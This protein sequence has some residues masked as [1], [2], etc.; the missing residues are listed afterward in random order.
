MGNKR[1][2]AEV[3]KG[4]DFHYGIYHYGAQCFSYQPAGEKPILWLSEFA[5]YQEG[6]PIRGGIPIILPWFSKGIHGDSS[7]SHG[8]ARISK[9]KLLEKTESRKNRTLTATF[10]LDSKAAGD[11]ARN[12]LATYEIYCSSE[13]LEAQLSITNT[14]TELFRMENALHTY[15]AVGDI[16]AVTIEGLDQSVYFDKTSTA[17]QKNRL[18]E[19]PVNIIGE[20]DRVYLS[21]GKIVV[22]DPTWKRQ[23]LIQK[24]GSANTVIWNPGAELASQMQDFGNDEW[25]QMLCIEAANVYDNGIFLGPQASHTLSQKISVLPTK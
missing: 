1:F 19:G 21:K 2:T 17:T 4:H 15:I 9:W 13:Y 23:L 5:Q 11:S 10:E 3:L 22:C 25:R 6:S 24:S 18:Q 16:T 14:G 20:T 12:W 8:Y 7:P